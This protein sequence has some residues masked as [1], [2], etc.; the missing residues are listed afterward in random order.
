MSNKSLSTLILV[1]LLWF[2]GLGAA[3]QFAKFAVPFSYVRALYPEA[4]AEISWLLTLISGLGALLGMTAGVLA[5]R[6]GFAKILV[7]A[8]L[9]GG[10]VSIWQATLPELSIMLLTRLIEGI[11]HLI[12]VVAA[13]TLIAQIASDQYRGLSMTLWSTFFGVSFALVAWF[14]LPYV[15]ANG[16]GNLLMGHGLFMLLVAV[17]LGIALNVAGPPKTTV[18]TP[19]S[20]ASVLKQHVTAY[21]SPTVFAPAIGWLFYTLTFVSL[22][23]VLPELL[24]ANSRGTIA[25]F[26]P[27]VSIITS[28]VLV[29]VLLTKFAATSVIIAGFVLSAAV[30][31]LTFAGLSLPYICIALFATLGLIQGA[32]FAAVPE[33]NTTDAT[34]ALANG[35]I[36]QMGNIGNL[37]GTPIL[38]TVLAYAGPNTML[39]IVAALYLLGALAHACLAYARMRKA[40]GQH[41]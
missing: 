21:S 1:L 14:G 6:I 13:P 10:G 8:L 18:T 11:S 16:L 4:G 22:L 40:T 39:L 27:I 41:G 9:L 34:R 15:A 32:S 31:S 5:A 23:A 19:F 25:G 35:A 17:I 7:F 36:A 12:I 37:V 33:L 29:S 20:I 24:P 26:M 30:V 38:L 2:A 28:L 3:A